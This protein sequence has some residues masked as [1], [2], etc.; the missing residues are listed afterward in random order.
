MQIITEPA[1]LQAIWEVREHDYTEMIKI[2]VDVEEGILA[3][4]GDM[5]ADLE[6]LL[7]EAGSLQQNLWGANVYPGK[8]GEEFLE[9]TSFINIRPSQGNRSMEVQDP[10]IRIK[11][12]DIVKKLL[13]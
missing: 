2:V 4:D 8:S 12:A 10:E 6:T 1:T 13:V 9:Y 3:I 11:V 7:L 5:H